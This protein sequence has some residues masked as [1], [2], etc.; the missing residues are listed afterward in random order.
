[1]LDGVDHGMLSGVTALVAIACDRCGD[2]GWPVGSTPQLTR[3]ALPGWS[4][5]NGLDECPLCR[6][7]RGESE[8]ANAPGEDAG[9]ETG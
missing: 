5:R 8:P 3:A 1:M 6:I 9:A 2:V 4:R 7:V